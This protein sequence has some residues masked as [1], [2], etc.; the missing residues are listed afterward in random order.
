[1]ADAIVRFAARSPRERQRQATDA[2]DAIAD[3]AWATEKEKILAI[4]R[5]LLG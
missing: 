2:Q 4:Y 3:L 1:M 5:R